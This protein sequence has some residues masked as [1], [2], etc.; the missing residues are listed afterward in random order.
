MGKAR[1]P[2]RAR[3]SGCAPARVESPAGAAVTQETNGHVAEHRQVPSADLMRATA[4]IGA[5]AFGPSD[6]MRSGSS[7]MMARLSGP[8]IALQPAISFSRRPQPVQSPDRPSTAQILMQGLDMEVWTVK[9]GAR[10]LRMCRRLQELRLLTKR[11]ALKARRNGQNPHSAPLVRAQRA[12]LQQ[13][14]V[15]L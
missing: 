6:M 12:V 13:T 8:L 1:A 7:F 10:I 9:A 3:R 4:S 11:R 15:W 14:G 5:A 2:E